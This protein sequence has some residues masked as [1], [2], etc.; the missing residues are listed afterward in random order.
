MMELFVEGLFSALWA[1]FFPRVGQTEFGP[2]DA[3]VVFQTNDEKFKDL[4]ASLVTN[5]PIIGKVDQL[6][7][8]LYELVC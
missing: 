4:L 6:R 2:F 8:F 5:T 7:R 3:E 1:S